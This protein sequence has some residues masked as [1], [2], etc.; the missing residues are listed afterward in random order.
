MA[1]IFLRT[2]YAAFFFAPDGSPPGTGTGG[3]AALTF[4]GDGNTGSGNTQ[5]ASPQGNAAGNKPPAGNS[6]G[7]QQGGNPQG[8]A[9]GGQQ[10]GKQKAFRYRCTEKCVHGGKLRRP[11]DIIALAE[12]TEIPRFELIKEGEG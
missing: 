8:N 11:G 9:A 1:R 5:G 10:G 6:G 2:L 12:K 7:G 3:D 4:D